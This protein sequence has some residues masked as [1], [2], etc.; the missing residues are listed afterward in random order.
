VL[1]YEPRVTLEDGIIELADWFQGQSAVD[2]V[3]DARAELV[4]R[5]LTI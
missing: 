1:G 4:A 3:A 5:G 2:R